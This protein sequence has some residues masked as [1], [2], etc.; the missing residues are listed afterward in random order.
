M[1]FI[2]HVI[3]SAPVNKVNKLSGQSIGDSNL[4]NHLPAISASSWSPSDNAW[5]CLNL[6]AP[7]GQ[8]LQRSWKKTSISYELITVY[9]YRNYGTIFLFN[10]SNISV[11]IATYWCNLQFLISSPPLLLDFPGFSQQLQFQKPF[12]V[13]KIYSCFFFFCKMNAIDFCRVLA[14]SDCTCTKATVKT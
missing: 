13:D 3:R 1:F 11:C 5:T 9:I 12:L 7:K 2:I 6:H 8:T 10:F 4:I 14:G